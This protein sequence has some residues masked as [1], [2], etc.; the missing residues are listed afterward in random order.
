VADYCCW[1]LSRK[2]EKGDDRSYALIQDK[3][4]SEFDVF[5][6]GRTFYY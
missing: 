5:R 4:R 3:I 1:A 6:S 2:W